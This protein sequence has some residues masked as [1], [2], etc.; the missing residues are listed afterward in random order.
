MGR[1]LEQMDYLIKDN[2]SEHKRER[3]H[4]IEAIV[5]AER[6]YA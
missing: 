2:S 5:L 4:V 3:R 6:E 1:T